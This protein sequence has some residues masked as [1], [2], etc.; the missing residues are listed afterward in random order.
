MQTR[1]FNYICSM[2]KPCFIT[3]F[4]LWVLT[5]CSIPDQKYFSALDRTIEL[6]EHYDMKF[7]HMK[8]SL[9]A[10][11]GSAGNDSLRWEAAYGLQK[12]LSYHN[13]DSCHYYIMKM[14]SQQG[15]DTRQH[16][17]SE[18]CYANILYK[19]DSLETALK[20]IRQI[21]TTD[22]PKEALRLY[23]DA[24]YHIYN[25]LLPSQ[26]S[27]IKA[28]MD[29]INY[30]WKR[31]STN[32][33][34][35]F[36]HNEIL[37][38]EGYSNEAILK[39]RACHLN[40]PN[41]TARANYFLAREYMYRGDI[42]KAIQYFAI[43]A[44]CDMRMSVKAYNA[45][46]Q[47]ARIL[48]REGD[49]ERADR[50]MRMTLKDAY[51]ANFQSRYDDVIKSELEIMNVLLEQ[52]QQKK[53]A[54]FVT[55]I[56]IA[57]LL[58]VAV[59]SLALQSIYSKRLNA[60]RE[61]LSEV[62]KI[63]DSFLAIYMEKCVDYLNKVDKYRS[64]LRHAVKH[65]GPDAAIA[66]LRHPSFAD[67]EFK[68]LLSDFDAAFLG[69]FPDFVDKVNEHMQPE[70]RLSMPSKGELSNELRVLALIRMGISKR[71]KIAKVLNMSVTTIYSYHCNLQKHSLHP[72][73]SFD[74]VISNL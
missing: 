60:S 24:G 45:L 4:I 23:C 17:I 40:S 70:H 50:Y 32:I 25:N 57:L 1:Y 63:K 2:K 14:S 64:S 6:Q 55:I 73:S 62:S 46:Y 43:S 49:I 10:L 68:G 51:A 5:S 54:Y 15:V 53:R 47:L 48:F 27:H 7:H 59:I 8:D 74:S 12:I 42:E 37:R 21:D 39:L 69:I 66:M 56:S 9:S 52:Q 36:Y 67:G 38:E 20:I 19:M 71:S 18:S 34:C 13:I 31:D 26:P 29:I 61:K 16:Y 35:A 41:D 72:D 58:I 65:E 11:Y 33:Q 30:W 44:E 22:I 3:L 28:K